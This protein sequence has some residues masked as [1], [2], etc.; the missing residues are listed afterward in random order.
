MSDGPGVLWGAWEDVL[1]GVFGIMMGTFSVR[2]RNGSSVVRHG[3]VLIF[4]RSD[5][6]EYSHIILFLP[7][8]LLQI[9]VTV[10]KDA[11]RG[12][13]SP[14]SLAMF[15]GC[16]GGASFRG[17]KSAANMYCDVLLAQ[18]GFKKSNLNGSFD[19]PWHSEVE[20]I[21]SS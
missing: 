16:V 1:R 21:P 10:V 11:F 19:G 2:S 12:H 20:R 18:Q 3:R 9:Q 5:W 15:V 17:G 8:M 13:I 14:G 6:R 7:S 4:R